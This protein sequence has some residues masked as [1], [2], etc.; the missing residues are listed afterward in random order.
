MNTIYDYVI[1][2]GGPTGMTL[3]WLFSTNDKKVALIEKNNNLGGYHY[4]NRVDGYY[5]EMGP[6]LY[7]NSYIMFNE[8]L[9]D[10]NLYFFDLFIP[11][12]LNSINLFTI[13][14]N[15]CLLK[16]FIIYM[17]SSNYGKNILMNNFMTNN[18]FSKKS[19]LHV[20]KICKLSNGT[21]L[22]NYT[23][24]QFLQ[25]FN[26]HTFYKLY[27]PLEPNDIGLI[28]KWKN[29]LLETKNVDIYFETQITKLHTNSNFNITHIQGI[30]NN[31]IVN[32]YGNKFILAIPPQSLIQLLQNSTGLE[33]SFGPLPLLKIW[34][35]DNSYVNYISLTLHY[36]IN[37]DIPINNI[38]KSDWNIIYIVLA[39][40]I[41][42]YDNTTYKVI[43]IMITVLDKKNEYE[44]TANQCS[45][46]EIIDYI[47]KKFNF[48]PIPDKILFSPNITRY[49]NK[50][51]NVNTSFTLSTFNNFMEPKS[52]ISN[53]LYAIGIY[54]GKSNYNF[55]SLESAVQ[56]AIN[57]A[58][59]E[60]PVL[61]YKYK[62]EHP[63]ML[64]QI[65]YNIIIVLFLILIL[66]IIKNFLLTKN[67][68]S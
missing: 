25:L 52:K 66:V 13:S 21:T 57:F 65:I 42:L 26:H 30:K 29:K 23:L 19:I 44:K 34:A 9:K 10:M 40:Y 50:W 38:I 46:T 62:N 43:S 24:Y 28:N 14:E 32:I 49:D 18:N 59:T 33:N 53:N 8:I 55:I 37:M 67:N 16:E 60:I 45:K 2:G 12:K 56:N 7:S 54:N 20:E 1:I 6:N 36:N 64:S 17:F 11:Y 41:N 58:K 47:K 68:E 61:K 5:S 22:D 15:I 3:A 63:K 35:N 27:Q 48:L 4:I 31:K 39:D 51:T